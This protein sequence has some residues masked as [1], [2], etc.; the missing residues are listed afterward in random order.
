VP[1]YARGRLAW[2][3]CQRCG[4]RF[5]LRELVLDGYYPNIRVCSGCYDPPQPQER[6][7]VVSDP[8]A[9]W[10]PAPDATFVSPPF[11]TAVV[12]AA[13]GSIL[14]TDNAFDLQTD[15]G[16]LLTTDSGVAAVVLT[17]TSIGGPPVGRDH[18]GGYGAYLSAGYEVWRSIDNGLSFQRLAVL[19]NT[20]DEFGALAIET[21]T[22]TD[23]A[24]PVN[25]PQY[26]IRGYDVN[27][28]A[29]YG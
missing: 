29:H 2:G 7:A 1:A 6:L 19:L 26:Y 9:L 27:E 21:L 25:A 18:V 8:I 10:K 12:S 3:L 4:L 16:I 23:I 5:Y 13:G 22:Y 15:S 28:N 14:T 11:L 24:P 20:A 17:W